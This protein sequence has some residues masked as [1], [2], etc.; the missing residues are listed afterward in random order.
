MPS[1]GASRPFLPM[2]TFDDAPVA[3]Y[4]DDER[5]HVLQTPRL[6]G[7]R[8]RLRI[9]ELPLQSLRMLLQACTRRFQRTSIHESLQRDGRYLD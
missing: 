8:V 2:D 9:H 6:R 5:Y 3:A 1:Q 4:V 7:I